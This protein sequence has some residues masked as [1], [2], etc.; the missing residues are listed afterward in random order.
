MSATGSYLQIIK[1]RPYKREGGKENQD[2]PSILYEHYDLPLLSMDLKNELKEYFIDATKKNPI[3]TSEK[4]YINCLSTYDSS[5]E[6]NINDWKK[7][8]EENPKAVFIIIN[9]SKIYYV[10]DSIYLNTKNGV[11]V[12]SYSVIH[13]MDNT[14]L[15]NPFQPILEQPKQ[16]TNTNKVHTINT[17]PYIYYLHLLKN[18]NVLE[19]Y[20]KIVYDK[21]LNLLIIP[22][23]FTP[24]D[25]KQITNGKDISLPANYGKILNANKFIKDFLTLQNEKK[26]ILPN[27]DLL[28]KLLGTETNLPEAYVSPLAINELYGGNEKSEIIFNSKAVSL[29]NNAV[30]ALKKEGAGYNLLKNI[31]NTV[32]K[33]NVAMPLCWFEKNTNNSNVSN[34]NGVI[35]PD[36]NG[37]IT[38]NNKLYGPFDDPDSKKNF[39]LNSDETIAIIVNYRNQPTTINDFTGFEGFITDNQTPDQ[40]GTI[41]KYTNG[42]K[43]LYLFNL[44]YKPDTT[45]CE[46]VETV[47][48]KMNDSDSKWTNLTIA[49]NMANAIEMQNKTQNIQE[50]YNNKKYSDAITNINKGIKILP[51]P[52]IEIV[53]LTVLDA[54][55]TRSLSKNTKTIPQ[56]DISYSLVNNQDSFTIREKIE[57]QD[58]TKNK[59]EQSYI[60]LYPLSQF[61]KEN[62]SSLIFS[63]IFNL[64]SKIK[65]SELSEKKI[66]NTTPVNQYNKPLYG[67]IKLTYFAFASNSKAM[68]KEKKNEYNQE[69][70]LI[71]KLYDTSTT[72]YYDSS[73]QETIAFVDLIKFAIQNV[74]TNE[75]YLITTEDSSVLSEIFNESNFV[76][77][78]KPINIKSKSDKNQNNK[79]K[80][81][82]PVKMGL[83][84]MF[85]ESAKN[86]KYCLLLFVFI[87]NLNVTVKYQVVNV[88]T[89]TINKAYD[90]LTLTCQLP[91]PIERLVYNK[92]TA[93]A[94][95]YIKACEELTK[96][97]DNGETQFIRDD[98]DLIYAYKNVGK[99][100]LPKL[101]PNHEEAFF[102]NTNRDVNKKAADVFTPATLP[103]DTEFKSN[104]I[105]DIYKE[106]NQT[107]N[108]SSF[109]NSVSVAFN[110]DLDGMD[111]ETLTYVSKHM[112]FVG[113]IDENQSA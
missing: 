96:S 82:T 53:T 58:T 11:H 48:K 94:E 31:V 112:N 6:I 89:P 72:F 35:G 86:I 102:Y 108:I 75:D 9:G 65:L 40:I 84:K 98:I 113:G 38:Q 25:K 15:W 109:C 33:E 34:E 51:E 62:K 41:T 30:Y 43:T 91:N 5:V 16:M 7:I 18:T 28:K 70:N 59:Q 21:L 8:E 47:L 4:K 88:N 71:R 27:V 107:N 14:C 66:K 76:K 69:K 46:N 106:K 99:I 26:I 45:L 10:Y 49:A 73:P 97:Q 101:I 111:D 22:V 54:D 77:Y 80:T 68:I 110:C 100:R 104:A 20:N 64:S 56:S 12:Q 37:V 1:L 19:L 55:K 36:E 87:Q 57:N 3:S 32:V 44:K 17:F 13:R 60:Y 50:L 78:N 39:N 85:F 79:T 83:F 92:F 42:S 74:E 23:D 2:K 90:I 81:T 67:D 93:Y 61:N 103:I 63:N 52:P 105:K 95:A 29:F 24:F